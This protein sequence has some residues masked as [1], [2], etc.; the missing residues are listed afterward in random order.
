MKAFPASGLYLT[1]TF[2]HLKNLMC[3]SHSFAVW[4]IHCYSLCRTYQ[5]G[6]IISLGIAVEQLKA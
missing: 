6:T 1:V 2:N 5:V 3:F 4:V